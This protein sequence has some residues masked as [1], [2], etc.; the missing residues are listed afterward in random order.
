MIKYIRNIE[1]NIWFER[2]SNDD[3]NLNALYHT[4]KSPHFYDGQFSWNKTCKHLKFAYWCPANI[5]IEKGKLNEWTLRINEKYLDQDTLKFLHK[6]QS[7]YSL[8]NNV[9]SKLIKNIESF[10]SPFIKKKLNILFWGNSHL[11]QIFE[12]L[13]CI[14]DDIEYNIFDHDINELINIYIPKRHHLNEGMYINFSYD[15]TFVFGLGDR[16]TLNGMIG[17][18]GLHLD[19]DLMNKLFDTQLEDKNMKACKIIKYYLN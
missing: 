15:H 3:K 7:E 14:I 9:Y 12:G 4:G 16:E 2:I 19:R 18:N 1:S 8:Y 5:S 6:L 17:W 10:K 13:Q 11:R